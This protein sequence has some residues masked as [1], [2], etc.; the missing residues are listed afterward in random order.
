MEQ[1]T[2]RPARV[3]RLIGI[4]GATALLTI[5]LFAPSAAAG[6]IP[7]DFSCN[8]ADAGTLGA[9]NVILGTPNDDVLIGTAGPDAIYGKGG[10]DTL[11]GM[12][13]DDFLCGG[14]GADTTR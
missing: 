2:L 10:N 6:G 7:T 1:R 12:G 4:L 13:G 11:K 8:P 5:G 3:L 9:V 14:N